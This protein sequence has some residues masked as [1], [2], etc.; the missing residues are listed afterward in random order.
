MMT[1]SAVLAHRG[2]RDELAR[3]VWFTGA[4]LTFLATGEET[5]GQFALVEEV[6]RK[7]VTALAPMHVH[8]REEGSFYVLEGE[9]TFYVGAA[10]IPAAAGARR[11]MP[12]G[13]PHGYAM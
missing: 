4:L 11:G 3:S 8:S 9:M 7:G 5:G 12:R 1:E 2:A 10:V 13:G 6:F